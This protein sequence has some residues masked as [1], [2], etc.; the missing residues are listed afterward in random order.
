MYY[1][2]RID[3][4]IRGELNKFI[5]VAK[6]HTRNEKIRLIHFPCKACRNLR[7]F[8]DPIRS[9]VVVNGFVKDYK[10]WK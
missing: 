1:A 5:Q 9:H 7:V 4:Y 6:N 2:K 8:S 10:I 3:A